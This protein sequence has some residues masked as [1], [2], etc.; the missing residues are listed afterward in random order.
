MTSFQEA[1]TSLAKVNDGFAQMKTGVAQL[2]A[3]AADLRQGLDEGAAGSSQIASKTLELT[4]GVTQIH[5]GQEQL[6][7]G[8][9]DL[10]ENMGQLQSGLSDS[11]EGLDQVS[12]GLQDAQAYVSSLSQSET[13]ETFY[14]P[15]EVLESEDFQNALNAYMS[16]DRK[17]AKLS[18]ILDVNPYSQ[19]AMPI[20]QNINRQVDAALNGT[21]LKDAK[22]A[23]GG[24]TATNV[25][26]K[27]VT[28]QDFLR[29][30][31]IMLIGITLVLV[32]IT[33][34]VANS[35]FIVGSLLVVYFVSLG[36]S[37]LISSHILH[38]ESLSWN[39]PFFS[40]IMIVALG[41]DYS[42]FLM[43]RYNELEGEPAARIVE[44]SR[45]IGGV[46]LSAALILGGT[47]AA[48]IP[49]GVLTLI[50]VASV[51]VIGLVLLGF[52]A[53]PMLMPALMGLTSRVNTLRETGIGKAKEFTDSGENLESHNK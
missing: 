21:E 22:V 44:A 29:T 38:V 23:I 5:D 49:S 13:S 26:L 3:G 16:D 50:Q 10:Q 20:L 39:V 27:E 46:V 41:V 12:D 32:V 31:T 7:Q 51:V 15:T 35:L 37:E 8:L 47:F 30:A 53:M 28:Q 48:L 34:S 33:R 25:D 14:L 36:M 43:M 42:I 4:S 1:N 40:F 45:H 6:L 9:K 17:T 2:Q 11:T 18:I 19:E 52:V 24:T